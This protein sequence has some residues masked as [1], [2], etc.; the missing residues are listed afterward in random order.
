MNQYQFSVEEKFV[1]YV[2]I[3]TTADPNSTSF[4]SS[5]KQKN[6]ARLLVNELLEIGVTDAEM[7][8]WGYVY[9]TIPSSSSKKNI[10]DHI[11][12]YL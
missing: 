11:K 12:K 5:E 7:D 2:Q 1:R 4:P 8:E 10:P 9:A 3:D 6:L